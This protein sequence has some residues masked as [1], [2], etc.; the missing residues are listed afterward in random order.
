MLITHLDSSANNELTV[1][2]GF[3]RNVL[4]KA[5]CKATNNDR[6]M[7]AKGRGEGHHRYLTVLTSFFL[8]WIDKKS[9][10]IV[11]DPVASW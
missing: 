3:G 4:I 7:R 8:R 1:N 10:L 2:V 11:L 6:C 9:G 5:C